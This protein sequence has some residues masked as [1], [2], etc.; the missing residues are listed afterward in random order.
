MNVVC[1][2]GRLAYGPE[3][4]VSVRPGW[5]SAL[6]EVSREAI[7]GEAQP[8]VVPVTLLLPPSLVATQLDDFRPGRV[9][10]IVGMLDVD[11]DHSPPGRPRAYHSVIA[12]RIEAVADPL[13]VEF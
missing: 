2:T 1:L 8:G 6:L 11:V 13:A 9:M 10:T 3:L 7:E 5:R 4:A 12:Q